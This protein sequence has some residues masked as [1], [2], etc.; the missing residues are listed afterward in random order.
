L[1]ATTSRRSPATHVLE[2]EA[3]MTVRHTTRRILVPL[4]GSELGRATIPHLRA[5]ATAHSHILLQRVLPARGAAFGPGGSTESDR[6]RAEEIERCDTQLRTLA[7]ALRDITPHIAQLTSIGD[8]VEEIIRVV[9]AH[10]ID[11]I[12]MATRGFSTPERPRADSIT[13]QIAQLATVPVMVLPPNAAAAPVAAD[14]SARYRRIIVPMDG[15]ARARA[16]IPVAAAL[17]RWQRRPVRLV[18]CI[19]THDALF[20]RRDP[21]DPAGERTDY[22]H[23]AGWRADLL[24]AL[25]ADAAMLPPEIVR[26][27][28][29]LS[30][31]PAEAIAGEAG[32]GDIIVLASHG[33]GGRRPWRLGSVAKRIVGAAG[34]PVVLVPVEERRPRKR[35]QRRP[36][37]E[38]ADSRSTVRARRR[39]LVHTS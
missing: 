10:E 21:I 17:A 39:G 24:T 25:D 19:P 12:L 5:L 34:A 33:E 26:E 35:A 32:P 18:R 4:D 30:G 14:G 9:E 28:A 3:I 38:I 37:P 36:A 2:Q 6:Q 7:M 15:S 27:T 13:S 16:A 11:L 23:Y 20:P 8:P 31:A 1:N 22:H 29:I